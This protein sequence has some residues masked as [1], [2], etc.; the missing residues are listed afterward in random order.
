M[1]ELHQMGEEVS[2]DRLRGL[3]RGNLKSDVYGVLRGP[4]G[5][6]TPEIFRSTYTD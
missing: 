3:R 5:E 4:A 6:G 2:L 1:Y